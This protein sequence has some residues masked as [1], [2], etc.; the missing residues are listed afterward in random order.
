MR[1]HIAQ[2]DSS[3]LV[4]FHHANLLALSRRSLPQSAWQALQVAIWLRWPAPRQA[5]H[6]SCSSDVASWFPQL[7]EGQIQYI[8]APFLPVEIAEEEEKRLGP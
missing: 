8:M 4:F 7:Q 5:M 6:T 2:A 1:F 3:T